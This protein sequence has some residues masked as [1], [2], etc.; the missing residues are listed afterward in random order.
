MERIQVSDKGSWIS[1]SLSRRGGTRASV[2]G[3]RNRLST[4]LTAPYRPLPLQN[5]RRSISDSPSDIVSN[6]FTPLSKQILMIH[7]FPTSA[8]ATS[9]LTAWINRYAPQAGALFVTDL[10]LS[11][12]DVY[13]RFGP[14]WKSFT[15]LVAKRNKAA[16]SKTRRGLKSSEVE[17]VVEA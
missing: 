1:S 15:S 11:K 7:S 4:A 14:N 10:Q 2:V 12:E 5:K 16:G 6:G 17:E 9:Q 3:R 8:G 13:A